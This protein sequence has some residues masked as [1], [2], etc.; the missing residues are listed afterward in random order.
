MRILS[1][2]TNPVAISRILDYLQ[3]EIP[4]STGPPSTYYVSQ[5]G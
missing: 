2:I 1:F 5:V 4:D 3:I